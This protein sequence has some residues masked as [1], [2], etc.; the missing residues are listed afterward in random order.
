MSRPPP[1]SV[2]RELFATQ[3]LAVLATQGDGQP[4][5]CLVAFAATAD[6]REVLF[7]TARSTRKFANLSREPR[8]SLLIDDR[9]RRE[10]DFQRGVAVTVTGAAR[11]T[12]GAKR[13]A[14]LRLYRTRHPSLEA[15]A[16]AP[17]S[18]L[19]AVRVEAYY[20]VRRFEEVDVVR[21]GG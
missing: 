19:V 20:V 7:A 5:A 8:V 11:D 17:T 1:E 6:L 9:S 18:A 12:A 10:T 15:F 13:E 21:P 4:Y 3:D 14:L 16:T 2:L